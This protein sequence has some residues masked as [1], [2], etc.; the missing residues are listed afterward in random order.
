MR[1]TPH[2]IKVEE[3]N[4]MHVSVLP[5]DYLYDN[6]NI[7]FKPTTSFPPNKILPPYFDENRKPIHRI[8]IHSNHPNLSYYG[9]K[10]FIQ[11]IDMKQNFN[12]L[13]QK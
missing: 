10:L 13:Y 1:I 12:F 3:Y 2:I 11:N 4:N 5:G 6:S 7:Y 8:V 9:H